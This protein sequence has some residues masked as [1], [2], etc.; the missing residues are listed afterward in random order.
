MKVACYHGTNAEAAQSILKMGFYSYTW[1]AAHLEDA[2][3]Y[4]GPHIFEVVFDDPPE[5]WQFRPLIA[6]PKER[7]V[8]YSVF[9]Q[10]IVFVNEELLRDI[11]EELR[12]EIFEEQTKKLLRPELEL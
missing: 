10:R 7:I 5:T 1:F 3:G 4:G 11:R 6:V 2:I 12:E 9:Q 8:S